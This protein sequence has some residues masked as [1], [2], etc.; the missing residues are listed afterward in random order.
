MLSSV[1]GIILSEC[2]ILKPVENGNVTYDVYYKNIAYLGCNSGYTH[3]GESYAVCTVTG[4]V[5]SYWNCSK[6]GTYIIKL[7]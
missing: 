6:I 2:G 3:Y 7:V 4:W 5:Y 1:T